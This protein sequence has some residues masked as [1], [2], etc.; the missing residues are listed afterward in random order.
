MNKEHTYHSNLLP[1]T[2]NCL[3]KEKKPHASL[4]F[5]KSVMRIKS[6]FWNGQRGTRGQKSRTSHGRWRSS[7]TIAHRGV[8][9]V[10]FV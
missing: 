7:A 10:T 8:A 9:S 4:D 6:L 5:L 3:V 1:T 2:Q